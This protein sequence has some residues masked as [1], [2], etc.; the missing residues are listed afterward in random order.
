MLAFNRLGNVK[1]MYDDHGTA[2]LFLV[3]ISITDSK[4]VFVSRL[5]ANNSDWGRS[6]THF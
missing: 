6:Y 3:V 4:A 2:S 1:N 5:L